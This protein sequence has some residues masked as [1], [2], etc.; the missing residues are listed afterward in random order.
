M[1]SY[2]IY[3]TSNRLETMAKNTGEQLRRILIDGAKDLGGHYSYVNYAFGG[4]PVEDVYGKKNLA[5]LRKLKREYDPDNKF[6]R[7]VPILAGANE[8]DRYR[9]EL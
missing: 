8:E 2:P 6:R 9:D 4:E 1:L 7:Y 5:R 3:A